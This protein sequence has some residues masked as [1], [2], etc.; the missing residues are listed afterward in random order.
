MT[1]VVCACMYIL[2]MYVCMYVCMYLQYVCWSSRVALVI[3]GMGSNM[4]LIFLLVLRCSYVR[5]SG[6]LGLLS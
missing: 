3:A 2:C 5:D 6:K 4:T 1:V